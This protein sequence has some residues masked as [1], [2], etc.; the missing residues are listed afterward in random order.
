[1]RT[2]SK[3]NL[4]TLSLAA[5]FTW[6]TLGVEARAALLASGDINTAIDPLGY[7]V[8][9]QD[10]SLGGDLIIG[11]TDVAGLFINQQFEPGPL[12]V[13]G[14]GIVGEQQGSIGAV[15]MSEFFSD[16]LIGGELVV[17]QEGIGTIDI[18]DSAKLQ[19]GDATFAFGTNPPSS[20]PSTVITAGGLAT[21]GQYITGL[22]TVTLD[23]VA[24]SR[25]VVE[26]LIVGDYG[27][28]NLIASSRASVYTQKGY[29]GNGDGSVGYVS[30]TDLGTRWTVGENTTSNNMEGRLTIGNLVGQGEIGLADREDQLGQG[31]GTLRIANQALVQISDE[32]I[33]GLTGHLQLETKGRLR[34]LPT[35]EAT[36]DSDFDVVDAITNLGVISGDGYIDFVGVVDGPT[37]SDIV[38]TRALTFLNAATGEIRNTS[39]AY[40]QGGTG[41][42]ATN[43]REKLIFNGNALNG[44]LLINNGT[45]ESLG[46]EMEFNVPVVNN[47]E[48]VARDAVMR[49]KN[50]L[51]SGATGT[52]VIGGESTIHGTIDLSLGGAIEV[53]PS[54]DV[55]VIGDL[56]FST[57]SI[58]RLVVG[59][60]T[61]AM[62][63][64]GAVDLAGAALGLS[65]AGAQAPVAGD[66]YEILRATGGLTG[67][68]ANN[69]VNDG[70]GSNWDI[71]YVGNSVFA[72]YLGAAV[73]IPGDFDG[74]GDVDGLDLLAW[75]RDPSIGNIA[76]WQ[77]NYPSPLTA[78]LGNLASVPEPGTIVLLLSAA[79]ACIGR[80][81]NQASRQ[82]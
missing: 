48:V 56:I 53:L 42:I 70:S 66:T 17:G 78:P 9:G 30:L 20:S 40:G 3:L 18:H 77:A 29:I 38:S 82:A 16:W 60:D 54:S 36:V 5:L 19:V 1:M 15:D 33:I 44:D 55:A 63:I 39:N 34:I 79:M 13:T 71:N 50:G 7:G 14:D 21:I 26:D 12:I 51:V 67:A 25:L 24:G 37:S 23:G 32:L 11:Q 80:K 73:G 47:F 57:A 35:S 61:G 6:G 64:T 8:P 69:P 22:G 74:D 62:T 72:I 81:R 43:Q 2:V 49:F 58:V 68:F 75:Q 52:I 59:E 45:I 4:A 41:T 31:Q 27:V 10:P 65:Y 46:G 76:D 28:G